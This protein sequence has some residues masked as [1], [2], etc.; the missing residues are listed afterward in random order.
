MFKSNFK[1]LNILSRPFLFTQFA[2]LQIESSGRL[3]QEKL[4]HHL[5]DVEVSIAE[6]VAQKSHHFFQVFYWTF[7]LPFYSDLIG[8]LFYH[9]FQVFYIDYFHLCFIISLSL[10]YSIFN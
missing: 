3:A 10:Y 4:S 5:D 2:F 7:V 1:Q 6:Q 9:F 8:L